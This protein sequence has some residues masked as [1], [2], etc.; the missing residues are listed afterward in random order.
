MVEESE[1]SAL[2]GGCLREVG[3]IAME[4]DTQVPEMALALT[5]GPEGE[6]EPPGH[7]GRPAWE[8]A[9]HPPLLPWRVAGAPGGACSKITELSLLP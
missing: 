8:A 5:T 9:A 4:G 3:G 1:V 7:P 2:N 6:V